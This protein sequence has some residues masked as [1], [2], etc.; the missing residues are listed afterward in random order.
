MMRKDIVLF[1]AGWHAFM[2][3]I[4]RGAAGEFVP[5]QDESALRVE[6][7]AKYLETA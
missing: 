3:V 5:Y 7:G 1:L 6:Y 2:D 4:G